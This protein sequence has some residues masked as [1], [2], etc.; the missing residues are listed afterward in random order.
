MLE[1]LKGGL[2]EQNV[3]F[4]KVGSEI[5]KWGYVFYALLV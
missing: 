2:K 1:A 4:W 5:W 3:W